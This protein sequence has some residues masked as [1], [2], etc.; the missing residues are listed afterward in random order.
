MGKGLVSLIAGYG[1]NHQNLLHYQALEVPELG[2][3]DA[4]RLSS[5]GVISATFFAKFLP[6]EW[7]LGVCPFR[8]MAC[9]TD[10]G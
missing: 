3:V 1:S 2:E 8:Y 9:Y 5:H 6:L 7:S 4:S 10:N